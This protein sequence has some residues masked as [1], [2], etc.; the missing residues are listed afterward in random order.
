MPEERGLR[1]H[2]YAAIAAGAERQHGEGEEKGPAPA[3]AAL[4]LVAGGFDQE[5]LRF[6]SQLGHRPILMMF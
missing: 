5:V 2:G 1:R 3:E 6:R 4:R